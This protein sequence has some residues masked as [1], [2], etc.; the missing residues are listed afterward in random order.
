MRVTMKKHISHVI[1]LM[2]CMAMLLQPLSTMAQE[3]GE[4]QAP[5]KYVISIVKNDNGEITINQETIR[6]DEST[7]EY[8]FQAGETV[9]LTVKPSEEWKLQSLKITKVDEDEVASQETSENQY[10]F[11]M[12]TNDV[13]VEGVF[14]RVEQPV[15]EEGSKPDSEEDKDQED[16]NTESSESETEDDPQ[17]PTEEPKPEDESVAAEETEEPESEEIKTEESGEEEPAAVETLQEGQ[18]QGISVGM[19]NVRLSLKAARAANTITY[20]GGVGYMGHTSASFTINGEPA[21]CIEHGVPAPMTG[22]EFHEKTYNDPDVLKVLY[23]GWGG[24]KQW[25]GFGSYEQGWV[26]TSLALSYYYSGPGSLNFMPHGTV[27]QKIG[28]SDFLNYIESKPTPDVTNL[29]LSTSYTE[30]YLSDDKTYQRTEN[31]KFTADQDNTITMSLPSGVT[32]VNVTTGKSGTGK[33]TIK[34][35]DTFYL[36]AQLSMNGTWNSGK[37]HGSM[38][39]L[40]PVIAVTAGDNV[41]D[42]VQGRYIIDPDNYVSL[43]VKWVQMGDFQITKFLG[44]DDELK[45]PAVGVEFTLTHEETGEKVVITTDENGVATTEDRDKYPIGRLIGGNWLVEETKS[46]EGYKPLDP[47]TVTITGQGQVFTY[48]AEDKEIFAALRVEKVDADTGVRITASG[49]TFKV[50]DKD[51]GKDIEWTDYSPDKQ[52]YTEFTTDENGQFTLPNQLP[53]GDYQLVELQA[54]EGY[55]LAE[56]LDFSVDAYFDWEKPLT[57]TAK[58]K[59]AMGKI[60]IEKVDAETGEAISGVTFDVIAKEDIVTGDGTI[61]ATAGDVVDTI[62]TDL[63]GKAESKELYLGS[64]TVKE[65]QAKPGYVLDETGRDVTLTY[66]DQN[67]PL[68]YES[69]TVEN[70]PTTLVITKTVKGQDKPLEGVS[71]WIWNK[72]M[73]SED[74]DPEFGLK[75]LQT[76][77]EN[78]QITLKYLQPGTYC[79]QEQETLPG[80]I[81]DDSVKEFTVDEKGQV[82]MDPAVAEIENDYTK[83]YISKQDATTGEELP[84][85]KLEIIEKESGEVIEKWVSTE[86]QHYIEAIPAGDYILRETMAPEGY[87]I[88]KEIRFTVKDTGEIQR[89]VMTDE[90]SEGTIVTSTP[91]HFRDGSN[92]NGGVKTGDQAQ[93]LLLAVMAGVAV[94]VISGVVYRRRK[95]GKNEEEV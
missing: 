74:L 55:T 5:E 91:D 32:L 65:K 68:V 62:T 15:K 27:A 56:P 4:E 17:L 79:I 28:F 63:A 8:E 40:Q 26:I 80:Y 53:Y 29:K 75:D 59:A 49:A 10:E 23:Y 90:L 46:V 33:V 66:Q 38:G 70:Q 72:G 57:V 69:L 47:F 11:I 13:M 34:G 3:P 31:I 12:P 89:V 24:P 14:E 51:T 85:A 42:L 67:T 77:D 16:N 9:R 52:V 20:H 93:I 54:P 60:Q 36:K 78:G 61:R 39:K 87:E 76:T 83:L 19:N 73:E 35:G 21:F 7:S 84:G 58:N 25:S 48:I 2:L 6:A 43:Q 92:I 82:Q 37:L 45:K 81:L 94:L 41:Q 71:F 18:N 95:V 1:S 88:A 86:E 44:S 22:T 30:S 64:Y 50:V